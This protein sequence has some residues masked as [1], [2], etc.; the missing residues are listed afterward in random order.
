MERSKEGY[1]VLVLDDETGSALQAL[2]AYAITS[3]D[4]ILRQLSRPVSEAMSKIITAMVPEEEI[5]ERIDEDVASGAMP[6]DVAE[7][8]K[9]RV[10]EI[11]QS[12]VEPIENVDDF[13]NKA[14]KEH[15]GPEL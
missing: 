2:L 8:F 3:G 10:R 15:E 11:K 4:P 9:E 13:I 5:F 14:L 12:E 1:P 7:A 6:P